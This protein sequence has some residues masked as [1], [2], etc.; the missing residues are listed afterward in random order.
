MN[1]PRTASAQTAPEWTVAFCDPPPL[2]PGSPWRNR[3]L[4][5]L[6]TTLL[7]PGFRHCYAL[8]P[9]HLAEGWLLFNPHSACTDILELRGQGHAADLAAAAVA[10][11]CHLVRAVARRPEV[12]VPRIS[13]TCVSAVAH[14]IGAPSRPWTT[15][16]ALYRRLKQEETA[17]GSIF[18]TPSVDTSAADAQAEE[19]RQEAAETKAK[20][21]ARLRALRAGQSGRSL[22]SY[23]GTGEQGVKTTLGAG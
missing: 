4:Y 16:F 7:K 3:L 18:S 12:W 22:L 13:A 6:L 8:R 20:T 21:E 9:L 11:R 10:G 2:P 15:P 17:M 5:R 23:S 1:F 14:L 19:A